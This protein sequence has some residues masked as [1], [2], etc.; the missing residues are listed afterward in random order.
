M[1]KKLLDRKELGKAFP[2]LV[3]KPY[4]L[5]WLVRARKIPFLRIGRRIYFT[6]QDVSQY[7]ESQTVRPFNYDKCVD[8]YQKIYLDKRIK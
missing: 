7:L 6:E 8:D 4:R 5:D 2:A 3:A 1:T